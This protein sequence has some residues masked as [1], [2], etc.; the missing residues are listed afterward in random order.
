MKKEKIHRCFPFVV[1]IV[2]TM[3]LASGCSELE[4]P[5]EEYK[6][7]HTPDYTYPL[8][9]QYETKEE[10]YKE[11]ID[12]SVWGEKKEKEI[13]KAFELQGEMDDSDYYID[14]ETELDIYMKSKKMSSM[15]KYQFKDIEKELI[16]ECR[17]KTVSY[18]EEIIKLTNAKV[19][20]F[21]EKDYQKLSTRLFAIA[22][23]E[24]NRRE[25][26]YARMFDYLIYDLEYDVFYTLYPE[27]L[28]EGAILSIDCAYDDY[29]LN[30]VA[31]FLKSIGKYEEYQSQIESAK[32]EIYESTRC[33]YEGCT[34]REQTSVDG[35]PG[36][37][38]YYHADCLSGKIGGNNKS[39]SSTKS[40]SNKQYDD[41]YN[42]YDYS[43]AEDFY[44]DNYDDFWDYEEA[45]DY[46]NDAWD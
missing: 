39:Y 29:D 6:K 43:D 33:D 28:L 14:E 34:S 24:M 30:C 38:C 27:E 5:Y 4:D 32:N 35:K 10:L 11:I 40:N 18:Y 22:S 16:K 23:V 9:D 26:D 15:D 1:I 2:L 21:E 19:F 25:K 37:Y 20:T 45:E 41:P 46:F 36:R 3:L 12:V 42:V 44:D 13:Q 31:D 17:Q 7:M 8:A